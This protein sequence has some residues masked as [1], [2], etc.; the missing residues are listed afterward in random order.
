MTSLAEELQKDFLDS[1]SES[2]DDQQN[3]LFPDQQSST[4]YTS[5]NGHVKAPNGDVEM[6]D[7]EE[8][9]DEEMAN[10]SLADVADEQEAKAKVEKMQL[11]GVSD[12][13]TVAGLMKILEPVLKV[14]H[15]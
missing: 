11:G 4:D 8:N 7:Q 14:S 9:G 5:A 15:S 2:E 13:R 1:G 3:S 10:D 6:Y 12:V